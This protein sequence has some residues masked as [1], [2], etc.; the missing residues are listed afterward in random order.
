MEF[1][2]TSV[3]INWDLQSGRNLKAHI[4]TQHLVYK[5]CS[6][7][8]LQPLLSLLMGFCKRLL[9]LA[10]I[11]LLGS[12]SLSKLFN[13]NRTA[14]TFFCISLD[15][16][17]FVYFSKGSSKRFIR[18]A[19]NFSFTYELTKSIHTLGLSIINW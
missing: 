5:Q 1:K 2:W 3:I 4:L 16:K 9:I 14:L 8:L 15:R 7:E 18:C 19:P 11:K 12:L 6:K 10:L 17:Y 13:Q